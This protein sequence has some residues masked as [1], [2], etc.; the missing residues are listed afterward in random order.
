MNRLQNLPHLSYLK[1]SS[2]AEYKQLKPINKELSLLMQDI[3][4]EILYNSQHEKKSKL[5]GYCYVCDCFSNLVINYSRGQEINGLKIP[6]WR[7]TLSCSNC[8]L[9]NRTRGALHIFH[10][11][12]SPNQ[13]SKIYLTEQVSSLY[14]YVAHKFPHTWGSEYLGDEIPYG[15]VTNNGIRNESLTHLSFEKN[16]F[17]YILSF[18]V[19]EHIPNYLQAIKECFRVL[20]PNGKLL[21]SV[22]FN[23][24]SPSNIIRATVD[25]EGNITHLKPPQYHGDPLRK[26]GVL[27][28]QVFGWQMLDEMKNIGFRNVTAMIYRS[29]F[30]GY[31]GTGNTIFIAQK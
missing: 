17:D 5:N 21:W 3:E 13:E 11:E 27:C 6:N 8:H 29:R 14:K 20:R 19:L 9:N 30:Y 1:A 25:T 10:Q 23:I 31:L 4:K 7:E 24:N 26:E 22:P 15:T 2:F 16:S 18:D 12:C 28:F